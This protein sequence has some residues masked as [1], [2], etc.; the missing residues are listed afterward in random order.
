M[1]QR[2][3]HQVV[4][5]MKFIFYAC[6]KQFYQYYIKFVIYLDERSVLTAADKAFQLEISDAETTIEGKLQ[7]LNDIK[8]FLRFLYF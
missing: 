2:Q 4:R 1:P 3:N 7:Y 6:V 8:I 5:Y